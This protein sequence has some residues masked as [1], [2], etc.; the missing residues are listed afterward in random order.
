MK[1]DIH[2]NYNQV[3]IVC[4]CGN[5]FETGMVTKEKSIRVEICS[6]CHPYYTG[7]HRL[8]DT[9]G[10]VDGFNKKFGA[11]SKFSKQESAENKA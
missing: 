1:V 2:P 9:E 4:S 5:E 8:V 11:F 10:R 3:K 6:K 7:Q